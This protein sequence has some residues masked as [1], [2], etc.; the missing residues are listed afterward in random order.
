MPRMGH[1]PSAS[2]GMF[3]PVGGDVTSNPSS[4]VQARGVGD[5]PCPLGAT[6]HPLALCC[7]CW[8]RSPAKPCIWSL[9][10]PLLTDSPAPDLG[11]L[12]REAKITSFCQWEY[13]GSVVTAFGGDPAP[14]SEKPPCPWPVGCCWG[15]GTAGKVVLDPGAPGFHPGELLP[16]AKCPCKVFLLLLSP[17]LMGAVLGCS[18][19]T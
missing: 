3:L 7:S 16:V 6:Q 13:L 10:F 19:I 18:W 17:V 2:C 15:C 1:G 12:R 9:P 5:E 14:G 4:T 11:F 8:E